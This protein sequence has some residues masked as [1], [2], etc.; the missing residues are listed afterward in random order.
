MKRKA[1]WWFGI[2]LAALGVALV[3]LGYRPLVGLILALADVPAEISAPGDQGEPTPI[4]LT[5]EKGESGVAI[6]QKLAQ[7]GLIRSSFLFQLLVVYRGVGGQLKAGQY[8]LY[9]TMRPTEVLEELQQGKGPFLISVTI[10]EGWRAEEVADALAQKGIAEREDFLQLVRRGS[11]PYDFLN[12]KPIGI[13]VE[14]YLF[15]ETYRVPP[16]FGA[17]AFVE[18]MLKTFGQRLSPELWREVEAQG[19]TV[20]QALTL[21]SIV[22]REARVPE[23]RPL[24]AGVLLNRLRVGMPLEADPTVQYVLAQNPT[25]QRVFGYWKAELA[26]DDLRLDSPYNTYRY[27]GLPPGP[28]CNPGLA[29]IEAV[30][31]PRATPY[32]YYVAG[33]GGSHAFAITLDE[34]LENIQRYR[35]VSP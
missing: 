1:P 30:A 11:F 13:S 26:N 32:L 18:L 9:P 20:H 27:P 3:L 4:S 16:G 8:Q 17:A 5:I 21:A 34:H 6:G 19:L 7:A 28:I 23:E 14:G 25:S 15:P 35:G 2:G 31:R 33:P 24:I 22:E 12:S 29:A 10:L